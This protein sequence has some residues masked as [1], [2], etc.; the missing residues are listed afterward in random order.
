MRNRGSG[1]WLGLAMAG[2]VV[3]AGCKSQNNTVASGAAPE[4]A[5]TSPATESAQPAAPAT[6]APGGAPVADPQIAQIALSANAG[7]SARGKLAESK[8]TN[9]EVKSFAREMVTDHGGLN[10]KAVAL[11]KKLNVTPEPSAADS[12]LINKVQ[13]MTQELQGKTGKDFDKTYM[14]QEVQI[15]QL[16]L[17]DLDKT[18]IPSAQNA[19]L[20][21]LLQTART[22]VEGHLKRAQQI[23]STLK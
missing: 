15:H 9:A 14:D 22:A 23:Q 4:S 1:I 10:K 8:A 6:P 18:L 3:A 16:V 2:L 20:K 11:A 7:D 5:S 13:G 17:D 12:D 19:D 21:Q